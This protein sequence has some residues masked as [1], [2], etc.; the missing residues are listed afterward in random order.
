M[1]DASRGAVERV[2]GIDLGDRWSQVCEL[3]ASSGEV[4]RRVR[5]RTAAAALEK[6]LL[7]GK[8]YRVAIEAGTHSGW[9]SRALEAAGHEVI[10]ANPRRVRLIAESRRKDDRID[11]ETLARLAR[12]DPQL[13]G[14]VRHR[15]VATQQALALIKARDTAV[16]TRTRLI[17]HCRGTVKALGERL[18]SCS[19]ESFCTKAGPAVPA[20]LRPAL[21]P[22]LGILSALTEVIDGYELAVERLAT[23]D[24]PQTALLTAIPGVGALTALAYVTTLGD[25]QRF[26][27]SRAVGAFLGLVP[28]RRDSGDA[29]RPQR[30][31][32]EGNGL[33]RRLLVQ[34]AHRILGPFGPPCD[35]RRFGERLASSGGRAPKRRAIIAVARKLA[36]L[37]HALWRNGQVY[38][39][40]SSHHHKLA[41]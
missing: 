31:S 21:E 41:A 40:D 26:P 37:M 29:K 18:P 3:E 12:V 19:A 17:L 20:A 32:K 11:A 6:I 27:S 1:R 10:V 7:K 23:V 5:V 14:P 13:L 33:M 16:R 25:P 28:G 4:L 34:C 9:V 30:I 39:P 36:V 35:L 2:V 38:E 24:Y 15:S 22:L 8:S